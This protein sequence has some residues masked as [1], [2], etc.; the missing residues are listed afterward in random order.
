MTSPHAAKA[1]FIPNY[2]NSV[3]LGR[4]LSS[5]HEAGVPSLGTLQSPLWPS[6]FVQLSTT[7]PQPQG[8]AG[9]RR[10]NDSDDDGNSQN[11]YQN[12]G[13]PSGYREGKENLGLQ[14]PVGLWF[15]GLDFVMSLH[16]ESQG[17]G[18]TWP[19]GDQRAV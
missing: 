5:L 6:S 14:H 9:L 12:L 17:R 19:K 15:E 3:H 8:P 4:A 18:L 7:V 2:P 1:E 10:C 13:R 16:A 11:P